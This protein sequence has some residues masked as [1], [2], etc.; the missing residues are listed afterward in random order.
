MHQECALTERTTDIVTKSDGTRY[1]HGLH[2]D[3][4][5]FSCEY[6]EGIS[7]AALVAT[8]DCDAEDS[9]RDFKPPP[10]S[11]GTATAAQ[12]WFLSIVTVVGD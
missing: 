11:A 8:S 3:S 4:A 7:S 12:E 2:T 9:S 1:V 5:A 10:S 6:H